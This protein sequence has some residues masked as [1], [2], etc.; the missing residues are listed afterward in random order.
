MK[1]QAQIADHTARAT[2]VT[3]SVALVACRLRR[4]SPATAVPESGTPARQVRVSPAAET[5]T[6]RN[7]Q[8]QRDLAAEDQVILGTKVVGRLSE[9][10]V[11]LGSRVQKG[12]AIARID[13]S[14]YRLRVDQAEAALQQARVRLGLPARGKSDKVDIEQTSLVRQAAAVLKEARLTHDRMVRVVGSRADRP[15]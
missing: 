11:D 9:I 3:S 10:R 7:G 13:P 8:R 6:A 5:E 15:S 1:S 14:D 4:R 12:Q 2:A